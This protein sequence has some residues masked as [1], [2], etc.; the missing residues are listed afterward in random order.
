VNVKTAIT[1]YSCLLF[2]VRVKIQGN[3]KKNR[4]KEIWES[5]FSEFRAKDY[6]HCHNHYH[7]KT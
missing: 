6:R 5:G 4:L 1:G 7:L 3:I 2:S